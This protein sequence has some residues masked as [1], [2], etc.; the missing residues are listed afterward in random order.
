MEALHVSGVCLLVYWVLPNL[1]MV[2]GL[3][4]LSLSCSL[5]GLF[6]LLFARSPI[7]RS[8]RA[9]TEAATIE[10]YANDTPEEQPK[11]KTS[12]LPE[13]TTCQNIGKGLWYFF[14]M[15][16]FFIQIGGLVAFAIG[17]FAIDHKQWMGEVQ[18]VIK[19]NGTSQAFKNGVFIRP[20]PTM[21]GHFLGIWEIPVSLF[22]ISIKWWENFV[23]QDLVIFGCCRIPI[24]S[25]K[26][27]WHTHR[28]KGMLVASIFSMCIL[29]FAPYVLFEDFRFRTPGIK[30]TDT[31]E[32]LEYWQN[33]M[34]NIG[35][36]LLVY[37]IS[38]VVSK[39][40]MQKFCFNLTLVLATPVTFVLI[41]LRCTM[42]PIELS[43]NVWFCAEHWS[44]F[45]ENLF[46]QWQAAVLVGAWVA[47]LII[48]G[49]TW[50]SFQNRLDI[51]E[52]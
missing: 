18:K 4:L 49:D 46:S 15:L 44:V 5:P 29:C 27:D 14:N 32:R 24:L 12:R 26:A 38:V 28:S 22:L 1:D 31:L 9:A 40:C 25:I 43:G 37:A 6:K 3:F 35:S 11:K 7:G 21:L 30:R 42:T 20:E 39:V 51:T 45:I 17:G 10:D 13:F 52:K 16:A 33:P 19:Q 36:S 23:D 8:R 2:R 50:W 34:V 41:F 47:S 48:G